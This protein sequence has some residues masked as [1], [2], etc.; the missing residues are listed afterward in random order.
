MRKNI[1]IAAIILLMS[2]VCPLAAQQAVFINSGKIKFE[3]K[4]N[5]FAAMPIF[6][7]QTRTVTDDQLAAYMQ[8]YRSN[9]PQFWADTFNLY[10]KGEETLYQPGN[11]DMGFS[12]SFQIPVAYK[13][14][15]YSNLSAGTA[16]T[17]K[18]AFEQVF[19]IKDAVKNVK[20]K[21]TEETR[22]IA[23]Y[24]CHRANTLLFDSIYVVAFYTDEIPTRGGPESFNGLPGMI[25]GIAI[26]YQHIT[27]FAQSV[28]GLD[29][30]PDK[31]K[32]PAPEKNTLISNS[33]FNSKTAKMLK[34]FGLT[35][36]WV[37][38]FMDL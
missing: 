25:L 32:L 38:F 6:L 19:F 22:E 14:K 5:T 26:P 9:S 7:K 31:W 33:D 23:G 36:S 15:V 4:V 27:I 1:H 18:Q 35:S 24:E 3:R 30:A 37:Q 8:E 20:W 28:V 11:P 17:Q 13:N 2:Y 29:T 34:Q 16:L 21:L 10:F 12:E